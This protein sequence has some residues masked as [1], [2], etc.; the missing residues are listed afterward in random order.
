MTWTTNVVDFT[1]E[2]P[3]LHMLTRA[4]LSILELK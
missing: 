1:D 2:T 3:W 4:P